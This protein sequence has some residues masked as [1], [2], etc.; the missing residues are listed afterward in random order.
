MIPLS[1]RTLI[2]PCALSTARSRN[3]TQLAARLFGKSGRRGKTAMKI[4]MYFHYTSRSLLRGGQ[5]TVLACF[6]VGVGV[7]ALVALQL[8]G[9]MINSA[10]TTNVRDANGGDIN[11]T[12]GRGSRAFTQD[13]LSNFDQLKEDRGISCFVLVPRSYY[14][15]MLPQ[16]PLT[17]TTI[18]I[19]TIGDAQATSAARRI[20]D[21]Y[22][23]ATV[24][25]SA[26]ALQSTQSLSDIVKKFLEI[27]GLLALLIG[28]VGIVNTMQVLLSRRKVEIAMLKT[29]GYRRTD[30]YLLF[31]LEAGL[32][33]LS[34]G[35]LGSV[36]ALGIS[37]IV[38]NV[39]EQAFSLNIPFLLN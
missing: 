25:T 2:A 1:Q 38:R 39:V 14:R 19:T 27:A 9:L 5:R 7:M 8:V 32:L 12:T 33:G 20:S 3:L 6:C 28:G 37:Y 30:L 22:P 35:V 18:D 21:Q 24:Q 26:Q 29:V 34:G 36:A 15:Q 13:D 23:L 4:S 17:F 11:V 31:G 16:T 10:M